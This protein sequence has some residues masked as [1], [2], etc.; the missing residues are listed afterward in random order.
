MAYWAAW[1]YPEITMLRRVLASL[2]VLVTLLGPATLT[3]VAEED[4]AGAFE[5]T[6]LALLGPDEAAAQVALRVPSL[7]RPP[8]FLEHCGLVEGFAVVKESGTSG[9]V[10][11]SHPFA[12]SPGE[13]FVVLQ[14][15][16]GNGTASLAPLEGTYLDVIVTIDRVSQGKCIEG[17]VDLIADDGQPRAAGNKRKTLKAVDL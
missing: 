14:Q 2:S 16:H 3:A 5:L 7:G 11:G 9:D 15:V 6:T 8:G 12:L 17:A 13:V 4:D 10:L 1:G